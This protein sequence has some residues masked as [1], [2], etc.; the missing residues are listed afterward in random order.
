VRLFVNAERSKIPIALLDPPLSRL[1]LDLPAP[2]AS[3]R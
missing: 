2:P 3:S 1:R